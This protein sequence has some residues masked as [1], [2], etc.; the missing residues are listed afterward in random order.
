MPLDLQ[1]WKTTFRHC[2]SQP[3]VHVSLTSFL[4]YRKSTAFPFLLYTG[5]PSRL[6]RDCS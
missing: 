4:Q 3:V 5:L 1:V 6:L 2:S